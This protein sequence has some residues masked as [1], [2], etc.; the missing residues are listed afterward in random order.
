MSLEVEIQSEL[1]KHGVDIYSYVNISHLSEDQNRGY[2]V[3]ILIGI[4]LTPGYLQ[5][6][7][8][9]PDYLEEMKR[10]NLK[11]EDEFDLK[12]KETDR[13]ANEVALF[14]SS[15]GFLAFP[16]SERNLY[17]SGCYDQKNH[18][19]PLP[20]KT[21]ALLAGLGWIGKHDLLI[22]PDQGSAISICTVLTNAPL[23]TV[24][25]PLLSSQCGNCM[26]CVN[27]CPTSAI[28]GKSW[29]IGTPRDEMVDVYSCT[30]CLKCLAFCPWTLTYMKKNL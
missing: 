12:E 28:K 11:E 17:Q 10:N 26:I 6:I 4:F 14:L 21:I 2:P 1:L 25:Q 18:R 8:K 9:T 3:A 7:T 24:A 29:N 30:T 20:H 13:I 22:T 19:T 5:M 15:K 27:S 23:Q 16:Q